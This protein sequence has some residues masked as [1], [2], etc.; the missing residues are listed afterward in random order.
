MFS[1]CCW[2]YFSHGLLMSEVSIPNMA[3][4]LHN[5]WLHVNEV[6]ESMTDSDTGN[7][8]LTV[9][10]GNAHPRLAEPLWTDPWPER[11]ELMQT[12]WSPL[13]QRKKRAS[14]EWFMGPSPTIVVQKKA[15][16]LVSWQVLPS[17]PSSD[18][19]QNCL[20]PLPF[21]WTFARSRKT[22]NWIIECAKSIKG[23]I[24]QMARSNDRLFCF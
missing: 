7:G 22:L 20:N 21:V 8:L 17:Q 23:K 6:W 1:F 14:G 4:C 5:L 19:V 15:T 16:S 11:V 9:V 24:M 13:S 2:A 12:S 3:L 18:V 10:S